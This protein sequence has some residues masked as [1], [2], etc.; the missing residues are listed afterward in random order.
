MSAIIAVAITVAVFTPEPLSALAS[1]ALRLRPP[2]LGR[3]TTGRDTDTTD[4]VTVTRATMGRGT[5]TTATPILTGAIIRT[6]DTD[7]RT[8]M[9]PIPSDSGAV[10]CSNGIAW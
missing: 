1:W 3:A 6:K 4:R 7:G 2:Q 10:Q 8:L 5:D 9:P